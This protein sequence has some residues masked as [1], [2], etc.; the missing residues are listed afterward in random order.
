MGIV[1]FS[2]LIFLVLVYIFISLQSYHLA[3]EIG[4]EYAWVS[5]VP[6]LQ[7]YVYVLL[8]KEMQD[9]FSLR[10]LL[11]VFIGIPLVASFVTSFDNENF[12]L[13]SLGS[14][15]IMVLLLWLVGHLVMEYTPKSSNVAYVVLS[16]FT[17]NLGVAIWSYRHRD[18]IAKVYLAKTK[19]GDLGKFD[20]VEDSIEQVEITD[21]IREEM[22]TEDTEKPILDNVEIK[23]EES[24]KE[25]SEKEEEYKKEDE[26]DSRDKTD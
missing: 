19:K 12:V 9:K 8:Y 20:V 1:I 14:V 5:F 13:N 2:T 18:E 3:K 25:E 11:I 6:A 17:G 15:I 26:E 24:E 22:F 7:L 23:K 10:E 16:F 21:E 4:I